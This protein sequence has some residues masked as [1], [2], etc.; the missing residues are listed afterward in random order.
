MKQK[1]LILI[2]VLAG[3]LC[4]GCGGGPTEVAAPVKTLRPTFT[5]MPTSTNTPLSKGRVSSINRK[6]ALPPSKRMGKTSLSFSS[7]AFKVERN[8]AFEILFILL[9]AVLRES[10]E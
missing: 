2:L 8:F 6:R 4:L 1:S 5:P 9:I 7:T 10:I 3:V